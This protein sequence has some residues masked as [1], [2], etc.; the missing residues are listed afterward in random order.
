[1]M[2]GP[3]DSTTNE[4]GTNVGRPAANPDERSPSTGRAAAHR[5]ERPSNRDE[6]SPTETKWQN[7]SDMFQT[8]FSQTSL[9]HFFLLVR[10]HRP[11]ARLTHFLRIGSLLVANVNAATIPL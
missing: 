4:G 11:L 9:M 6:R 3:R 8:F 5:D 2:P 7:E 10:K 1:M